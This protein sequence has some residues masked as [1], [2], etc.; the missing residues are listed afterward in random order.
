MELIREHLIYKD[1]PLTIC[2]GTLKTQEQ[3]ECI[4]L[5]LATRTKDVSVC[6]HNVNN[7]FIKKL[8]D[9]LILKKIDCSL[10]SEELLGFDRLNLET[11]IFHQ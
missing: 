9:I 10:K 6:L 2:L 5:L 1:V 11:K 7:E 4:R 8:F 3:Y